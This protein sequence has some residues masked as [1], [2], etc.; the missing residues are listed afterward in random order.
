VGFEKENQFFYQ[1]PQ[2][3]FDFIKKRQ[4]VVNT[5]QNSVF[6]RREAHIPNLLYIKVIYVSFMGFLK[7]QSLDQ[8]LKMLTFGFTENTSLCQKHTKTS[9]FFAVR[10][11]LRFDYT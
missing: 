1:N 5:D 8:N 6:L 7:I 4:F 3:A 9:Y 2:S 10:P 11:I